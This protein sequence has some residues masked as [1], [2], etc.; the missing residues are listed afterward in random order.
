MQNAKIK[1]LSERQSEIY[2]E[3]DEKNN[4]TKEVEDKHPVEVKTSKFK[5][6]YDKSKGK[7]K[8]AFDKLKEIFGKDKQV[9]VSKE[10]DDERE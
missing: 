2:K 1:E 6:F 3:L 8:Q 5:E 4:G 9:D 10:N 7:L